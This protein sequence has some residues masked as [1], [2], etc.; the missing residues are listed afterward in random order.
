M[1]PIITSITALAATLTGACAMLLML[2]LRGNP[3]KD[4][5]SAQRLIKAH[6]ITGYVFIALFFVILAIMFFKAGTYQEEL[7]PRTILHIAL[8]LLIIPL[9]TIKALFIRRFKQLGTQVPGLGLAVFLTVFLLNSLAAG[10]YFLYQSDTRATSLPEQETDVSDEK[11]GQRL[12]TEKCVKCHTL[13]RIFKSFKTEQG[14]TDTI[15][16][17]SVIDTP[18]IQD[19]DAK[20]IIHYL[21][22]QQQRREEQ[23]ETTQGSGVEIGRTLVDQKCTSC[24]S[25]EKVYKVK[26]SRSEWESTVDKMIMYS[27]RMDFLNQKEKETVID[28]LTNRNS[29]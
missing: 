7:T 24:H 16:R 17:M 18:N 13:E 10:Y 12:V 6:R 9:L 26:K 3:K 28:F 29:E 4:S 25:L 19:A 20:H 8:G 15:N 2:E 1:N 27:D 5:K 23:L 14:W 21:I 11:R 22:S